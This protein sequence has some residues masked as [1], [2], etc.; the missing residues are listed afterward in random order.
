MATELR[1]IANL[2]YGQDNPSKRGSTQFRSS[3]LHHLISVITV[4]LYVPYETVYFEHILNS[5]KNHY[6]VDLTQ[7]SQ[8][9]LSEELSNTLEQDDEIHLEISSLYRKKHKEGV[10]SSQNH[11]SSVKLTDTNLQSQSPSLHDNLKRS[12]PKIKSSQQHKDQHSV[13]QKFKI[14]TDSQRKKNES[15]SKFQGKSVNKKSKSKKKGESRTK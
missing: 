8:S 1:L 10:Q 3:Q 12:K 11:K 14:I 7:V 13:K 15:K 2:R 4:A 6:Q 9:T 5:F